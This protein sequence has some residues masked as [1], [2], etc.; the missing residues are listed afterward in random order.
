MR[1]MLVCPALPRRRPW[2]PALLAICKCTKLR[3]DCNEKTRKNA[4][5]PR[6]SR[7]SACCRPPCRPLGVAGRFCKFCCWRC[8]H[9]ATLWPTVACRRLRLAL[10]NGPSGLA[11][12]PVLQR[13]TGRLALRNGSRLA[14]ESLLSRCFKAAAR[15]S[16]Q[17]PSGGSGS[18][19]AAYLARLA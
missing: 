13:K 1:L 10:R 18:L 3:A 9:C 17:H 16:R 4:L 2:R 12:R 8:Q 6:F 15:V 19:R 7:V 14:C 11:E 5:S